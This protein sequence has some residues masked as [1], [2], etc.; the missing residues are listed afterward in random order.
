[1]FT[2]I[3]ARRFR[4]LKAIEQ[5]LGPFRA[6]V[7][8]N[9]SG[10]TT[11]LDV[12]AFLSDLVRNRGDV[13]QTVLDRSAAF[14]QLLW[15]EQGKSFQLAVEAEIPAP[16]RQNENQRERAGSAAGRSIGA[17]R[18]DGEPGL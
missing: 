1:M 6:L 4:S 3:E 11:F 7:G 15:L 13:R 18:A 12:V 9:G 16:V 17:G 10:K 8:P 14:E 5:E 2:R